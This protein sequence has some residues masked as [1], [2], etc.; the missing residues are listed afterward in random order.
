MIEIIAATVEDAIK[1]ESCG[2]E[3]IELVSA[4]SEGGLTPSYGTIKNVVSSVNIPVNVIIRPHSKNFIYSEEDMKVMI[5][6]INLV[7]ELGANGVVIGV[8]TENNEIDNSKLERLIKAA[9][10]LDITF[11]RAIEEVNNIVESVKVLSKYQEITN[12]LTSGG[13]GRIEDNIA[14]LNEM[15][16]H[17]G[18]I[19]ILAGGGLNLN[20]IQDIIRNSSVKDYHFGTAIREG[21]RFNGEID[22]DK[23]RR[24]VGIVKNR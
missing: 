15:T 5:E 2:G 18:N 19:R 6:D 9:D 16:R 22:E 24:L 10:K 12:I 4:L 13:S 1:I 3:R 11:H 7:K 20:N 14:V 8:L 17:S 21:N 23:L